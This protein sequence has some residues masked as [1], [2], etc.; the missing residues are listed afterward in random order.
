MLYHPWHIIDIITVLKFRLIEVATIKQTVIISESQ[1]TSEPRNPNCDRMNLELS[2]PQKSIVA[3]LG[4]GRL[5]N[6]MANFASC[7]AIFKEY[8]MYHYLNAMQ[9]K[10]LKNVFAMPKLINADNASYYFWD[11]GK[12]IQLL[13]YKSRFFNHKKYNKTIPS[14]V[15]LCNYILT[16]FRVQRRK[17]NSMERVS[18]QI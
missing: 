13:K 9:L 4:N 17:G 2:H 10:L 14:R 16:N 18:K 11:E 1:I 3:S 15:Y 5:G 6:Q 7:F 8:G 12:Y